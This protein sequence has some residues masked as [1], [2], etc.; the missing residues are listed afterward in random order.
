MTW[1]TSNRKQ[2][3]RASGWTE[4]RDANRILTRDGHRCYLRLAGICIGQA[5][6][7]DHLRALAHGGRD[8]DDNKRA[9]CGPCHTAKTT[10]ER[11]RPTNRRPA[12]P[13][14]GLR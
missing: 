3:R 12:E 7:V 13:H 6:Q 2:N 8:T 10:S 14:P 1:Q 5:T 9:I 4:Q 11:R